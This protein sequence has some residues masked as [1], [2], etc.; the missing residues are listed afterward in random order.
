MIKK[1]RK[2]LE[3]NLK[4]CQENE[5]RLVVENKDLKNQLEQYLAGDLFATGDP[6][7]DDPPSIDR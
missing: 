2:S 4:K 3:R 5:Q 7:A 1:N 6:F